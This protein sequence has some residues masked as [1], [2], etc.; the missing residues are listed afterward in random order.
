MAGN[1]KAAEA[2]ILKWV[3][4]L[5]PSGANTAQYHVFFKDMDDMQFDAYM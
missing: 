1:R 2:V 4:E 3:A 5:D